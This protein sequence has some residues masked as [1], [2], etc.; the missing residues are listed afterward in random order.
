MPNFEF[1][2]AGRIIFGEGTVGQVPSAAASMGRRVLLVTGAR[3]ERAAA[4]RRGLC[5]AGL[6]V[7]DFAVAGEP[8]VD[9]I[10]R[11][12]RDCDVLVACGG[13]SV[14]D[15]GKALAALASNPGDPLDYLE[16]IGQGR[17]LGDA[18]A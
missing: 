10:R 16:V 13:G 11:A 15:A 9:L 18:A 1:A 14:L 5:D 6:S 8:T 3:T 2:T 12:P 7:V 17:P 4:L